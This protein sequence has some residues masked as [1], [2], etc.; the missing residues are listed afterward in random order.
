MIN[1]MPIL[2]A[3]TPIEAIQILTG[4]VAASICNTAQTFCHGDNAQY[5]SMESC[6]QYLT[7]ETRFGAAYEVGRDTLLCRMVHQNMV[8][9]RPSVHWFVVPDDPVT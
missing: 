7:G 4:K 8:P 2:N 9:Y 3:T 5:E 1:S 6:Y